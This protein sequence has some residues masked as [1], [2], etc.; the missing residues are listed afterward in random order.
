MTAP[1]VVLVNETGIRC[2]LLR[3]LKFLSMSVA[4]G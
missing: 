4:L 3:V 1:T 2:L